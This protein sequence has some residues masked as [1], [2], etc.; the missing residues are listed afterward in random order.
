MRPTSYA[1]QL[2]DS[3]QGFL[4]I[5]EQK[6]IK[7]GLESGTLN[8]N[9]KQFYADAK[10]EFGE[11]VNA[12]GFA[13]NFAFVPNFATRASR[14]DWVDIYE[15]VMAAHAKK[16]FEN[17]GEVAEVADM[18]APNLGIRLK[19]PPARLINSIGEENLE[20]FK[21][22]FF[23]ARGKKSIDWPEAFKKIKERHAEEPFKNYTQIGEFIGAAGSTIS[24]AAS[25]KSTAGAA[26]KSSM[27]AKYPEFQK[28]F[29]DLD[30]VREID[31]DWLDIF[32]NL[33][34][35]HEREPISGLRDAA[36]SVG[37]GPSMFYN[38][39]SPVNSTAKA[40][41]KRWEMKNLMNS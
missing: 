19:N 31:H 6:R 40:A 24:N 2:K 28:F 30:N 15:K 4:S 35:A 25:G 22:V 17:Q 12:S 38:I 20:R 32:D 5:R 9:M 14:K 18:A 26:A 41:K 8:L 13:P 37:L 34:Q 1:K 16:P 36:K 10:A 29:H 7:D 11:I 27:G 3:K 21:K 33:K 39:K 23:E